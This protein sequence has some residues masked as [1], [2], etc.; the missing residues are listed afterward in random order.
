MRIALAF[1]AG[2]LLSGCCSAKS[3]PAP[4]LGAAPATA[5][6]QVGYTVRPVEVVRTYTARPVS[7]AYD[8]YARDVAYG[9]EPQYVV[10]QVV[11]TRDVPT[12]YVSESRAAERFITESYVAP[13]DDWS[14]EGGTIVPV[15][16][17]VAPA[18]P[19]IDPC[20]GGACDVPA[21]DCGVPQLFDFDCK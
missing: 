15:S 13:S 17:P 10:G 3:A 19:V 14:Y 4:T 9:A 8:P 18:T 20:A 1:A 2:I 6:I 16:K 7:R 12:T 5:P 21:D 11:E